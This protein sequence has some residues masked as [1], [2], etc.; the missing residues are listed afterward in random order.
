M[1]AIEIAPDGTLACK[2]CMALGW[3]QLSVSPISSSPWSKSA[4]RLTFAEYA[5]IRVKACDER[6][7]KEHF[8]TEPGAMKE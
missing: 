3:S 4:K 7:E 1:C 8:L 6:L 5:S 2:N